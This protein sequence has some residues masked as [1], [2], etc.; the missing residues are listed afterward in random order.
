MR[1][2]G[3][4]IPSLAPLLSLDLGC[5]LLPFLQEPPRACEKMVEMWQLTALLS[6]STSLGVSFSATWNHDTDF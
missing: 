5:G 4:V 1:D 6:K 3:L 2:S